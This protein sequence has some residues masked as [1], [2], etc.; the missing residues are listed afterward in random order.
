MAGH[1]WRRCENE[2]DLWVKEVSG[3]PCYWC[4]S[5]FGDEPF[6]FGKLQYNSGTEIEGCV[7][8]AKPNLL[9]HLEGS[10]Q[11]P[12]ASR[13]DGSLRDS[14]PNGFG[15]CVWVNGNMYNGTWKDGLQHGYG[16]WNSS[17]SS[18]LRTLGEK[19][20]KH[21]HSLH[22]E[23][24]WSKN[25]MHGRGTLTYFARPDNM[26]AKIVKDVQE[27][28]GKPL[29]RFTGNF[30]HGYALRGKLETPNMTY[31]EVVFEDKTTC[32]QFAAWYWTTTD[33]SGKA[34]ATTTMRVLNRH[35]E[36]Y[37]AVAHHMQGLD[38]TYAVEIKSIQRVQ[39]HNMRLLFEQEREAAE[40]GASGRAGGAS[41]WAFYAVVRESNCVVCVL[42]T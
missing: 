1:A 14:R 17:S 32:G 28:Q 33:G 19:E 6:G 41:Q 26:C 29:R 37:E 22:Y 3:I 15:R 25:Q 21:A 18:M 39:N 16:E 8:R 24:E 35:E 36:E 10:I 27:R 2:L 4:G 20:D 23:G 9:F 30:E 31:K 7:Q 5:V 13:Y 34:P 38:T 12:D 11:W 40:A 42:C